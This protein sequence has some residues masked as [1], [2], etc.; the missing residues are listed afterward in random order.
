M[1]EAKCFFLDDRNHGNAPAGNVGELQKVVCF[2][3]CFG[4]I[5]SIYLHQRLAGPLPSILCKVEMFLKCVHSISSSTTNSLHLN[6]TGNTVHQLDNESAVWEVREENL[7]RILRNGVEE[8]I[9]Q[10]NFV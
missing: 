2:Q 10:L 9:K 3:R 5:S 6:L 1:K 4:N 7:P 8:G